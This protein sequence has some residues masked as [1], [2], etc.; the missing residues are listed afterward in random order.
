MC[1]IRIT[2]GTYTIHKDLPALPY[3]VLGQIIQQP[4]SLS[5]VRHRK[6]LTLRELKQG[7]TKVVAELS[8]KTVHRGEKAKYD[9]L[10]CMHHG[11]SH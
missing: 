2:C 7:A 11:T 5:Y 3:A 1:G 9:Q 4:E 6:A 8:L 10:V